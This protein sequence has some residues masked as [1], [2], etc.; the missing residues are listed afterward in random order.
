MDSLGS[1]PKRFKSSGCM[2]PG[3]TDGEGEGTQSRT[4]EEREETPS[5]TDGEGEEAQSESGHETKGPAK[6][7]KVHSGIYA[8]YRVSS[9]FEI[10]HTIDLVL[11]GMWVGFRWELY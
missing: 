11:I 4:D 7:P 8:N 1:P 10:T 2:E 9:S 6:L 5:E 3:G